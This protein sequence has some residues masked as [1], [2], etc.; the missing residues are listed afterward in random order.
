MNNYASISF[1]VDNCYGETY[2][3]NQIILKA[4]VSQ[5]TELVTT[6]YLTTKYTNSVE[7]WTDYYKKTDIDTMF[8]SYSTGSYVGYNF[9]H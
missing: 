1:I 2:L 8:L 4:Y 9:L 5:L 3:D 7:L 6:D